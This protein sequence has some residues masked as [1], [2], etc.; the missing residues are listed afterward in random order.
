MLYKNSQSLRQFYFLGVITIIILSF[1]AFSAQDITDMDIV[2]AIENDLLFD[3]GVASHRIDINCKNGIVTLSGSIDNLLARER[4]IAIAQSIKGVRSVINEMKVKPVFRSDKKIKTAVRNALLL[5]PITESYEI[6]VTAEDG[7]VTLDGTVESWAER[8]FAANIAKGVSGISQ[9]VN[10]IDVE[11]SGIR[12]DIEIDAEIER[13]LHNDL[14]IN[15]LSLNVVVDHGVA[16][17]SGIVGSAF[18]KERIRFSSY[19]NGV[20][21]VDVSNLKVEWWAENDM[22]KEDGAPLLEDDMVRNAIYDAL[23]YDPRILPTGVDVEVTEGIVSLSGTVDNYRAR[24]AAEQ[25]AR[26]TVGVA[27]VFNYIKVRP[28]LVI[29]DKKIY[30]YVDTSV[31]LDPYVERY[32]FDFSVING[33]VYINGQVDNDFDKLRVGQVVGRQPGV[34]DIANNVVVTKTWESKP[35][36]AIKKDILSQFFWSMNV[37]GDEIDVTVD[38]GQVTLAGNVDSKYEVQAAVKN[39]YEGGAESVINKLTV[40]Q[41]HDQ[42]DFLNR[43]NYN[44]PLWFQ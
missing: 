4:A 17:I 16:K 1:S 20:V 21:D 7:V 22:R 2:R 3:S 24:E 8:R 31:S 10:Q 6:D 18:E 34:I 41:R 25:D 26:H 38:D 14:Y 32:D 40:N 39:A 11:Y 42:P 28:E 27:R 30:D 43:Y 36:W 15:D 13:K 23:I 12:S 29:Q 33:K 37:D 19:V 9:V 5:D 35:D 44:M